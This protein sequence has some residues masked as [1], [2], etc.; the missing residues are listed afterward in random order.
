MLGGKTVLYLVDAI[1]A[2]KNW[3]AVPSRW[4]LAPF[5]NDWPSSIFVSMDPVAIDS[6]AFDFLSQQWPDQALL[7]EWVR[8]GVKTVAVPLPGT[9]KRLRCVVSLLQAGGGCSIDDPNMRDEEA[10]ARPP[11]RSCATRP[12]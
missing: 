10:T 8:R 2:G 7:E 9:S 4:A 1:F 12:R 3:N 6:V 5:N 11:P